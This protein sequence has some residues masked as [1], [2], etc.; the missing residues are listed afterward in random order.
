MKKKCLICRLVIVVMAGFCLYQQEVIKAADPDQ[1]NI[2]DSTG[3]GSDTLTIQE[4]ITNRA[5]SGTCTIDRAIEHITVPTLT[6]FVPENPNGTAV[7][8]CPGGAYQRVVYDVEGCD[9][10]RWYNQLGVTAFVL[11]YR[12]PVDQHI[13]SRVVPLQDAQRAMRYVKMNASGWGLDTAKIGIMGASA[14]GH[15]AA[16]LGTDFDKPAYAPLET[17]DSIS[18]RPGFMVLLYPVISMDSS[19]THISTRESLLGKVYTQELLD[20][21][22]AE[23][24]VKFNTPATFMARAADDYGVNRENCNRFDQALKDAG[25]SSEL[26]IYANGGH[27]VGICKT[28][29]SD[30]ANWPRDCQNWLVSQGLIADS[31]YV[32]AIADFQQ[33]L[34]MSIDVYPNPLQNTSMLAYK[35]EKGNQVE[36][37]IFDISGKKLSNLATGYHSRG[38]YTLELAKSF[39]PSGGIYIVRLIDN[40]SIAEQKVVVY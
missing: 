22:S 17:L 1:I 2:W 37:S 3:P 4:T 36:L 32:S 15:L 34:E 12:L 16:S 29:T 33:D 13:D 27:G 9:I 30:L 7:I 10:A 14:G 26:H 35:V 8:I 28:G 24:Q 20:E 39:F 6:P 23:K 21:F 18:A 11:K 38:C 31:F 19:I 40:N 25:V 5:L